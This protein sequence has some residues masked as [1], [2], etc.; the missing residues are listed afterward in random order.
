MSSYFKDSCRVFLKTATCKFVEK[1]PLQYAVNQ[2]A[3]CLDPEII[4]NHKTLAKERLKGLVSDLIQTKWITPRN[5][6]EIMNTRGI[7][8]K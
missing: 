3:N 1:S 8:K 5:G 7:S 4:C 6:D 2:N